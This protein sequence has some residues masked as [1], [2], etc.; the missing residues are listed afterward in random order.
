MDHGVGGGGRGTPD[1]IYIYTYVHTYIYTSVHLNI[2][3]SIRQYVHTYTYFCMY[4]YT[5]IHT[6]FFFFPTA[7]MVFASVV[8]GEIFASET[9][10]PVPQT[11]EG[12]EGATGAST[13]TQSVA[14]PLVTIRAPAVKEKVRLGAGAISLIRSAGTG[15]MGI[16]S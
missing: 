7:K 4:I 12:T 15:S 11:S 10:L 13:S 14:P 3:T 1:H 6:Y 2:Y 8:E 5:N 9:D 16:I